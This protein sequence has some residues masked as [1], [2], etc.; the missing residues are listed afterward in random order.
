MSFPAIFETRSN[1]PTAEATSVP[2][3]RHAMGGVAAWVA[4]A[5][6]FLFPATLLH[7]QKI[8][9]FYQSIANHFTYRGGG[10]L[11]TP[12]GGTSA[13]ANEGWNFGAGAGYRMN[14]R[15]NILAEWQ[16]L[17]TGMGNGL[18]R[19]N[20]IA[21]GSYRMEGI[22][23]T[24]M[25]NYWYHGKFGSYVLGGAGYSRTRT[26]YTGISSTTQCYTLCTCYRNCP[27]QISQGPGIYHTYS[28]QALADAGLGFTMQLS[29]QHRYRLYTEARYENL[30]QNSH[31]PPY[32]NVEVIP[33]TVGFQW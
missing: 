29:R 33:L 6:I 10:G 5:W 15:F 8:R 13:I 11:A 31:L 12:V 24:P 19:Y 25:Y 3:A 14:R 18:L 21:S 17:R 32:K 9:S 1:H 4:L 16:Y 28:N 2:H 7:G 27:S 26:T 23:L 22:S 20:L 30:F